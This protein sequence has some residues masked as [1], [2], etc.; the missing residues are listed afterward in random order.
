MRIKIPRKWLKIG[1]VF[2]LLILVVASFLTPGV[3]PAIAQD[4]LSG[5]GAIVSDTQD[6]PVPTGPRNVMTPIFKDGVQIYPIAKQPGVSAAVTVATEQCGGGPVPYTDP[7]NY[8]D[9]DPGDDYLE[10]F[11]VEC[12][13]EHGFPQMQAYVFSKWHGRDAIHDRHD[14]Q[15]IWG[16]MKVIRLSDGAIIEN[17]P[18][19]FTN[20]PRV[21]REQGKPVEEW[22][23]RWTLPADGGEYKIVIEGWMLQETCNNGSGYAKAEYIGKRMKPT[24]TSMPSA[25]PKPHTPT[26]RPTNTPVKPTDTA[27]PQLPTNTP[28]PSATATNTALPT[29][30][31]TPPH[32]AT[33]TGTN[34][35][36]PTT[37]P[38]H[39]ATPTDTPTVVVLPSATPTSVPGVVLLPLIYHQ[40]YVPPAPPSPCEGMHIQVDA[41]FSGQ[42]YYPLGLGPHYP[43]YNAGTVRV[44]EVYSFGT[45]GFASSMTRYWQDS[46]HS[47]PAKYYN[48]VGN[49]G[50]WLNNLRVTG[51]FSL[52]QNEMISKA[53]NPVSG[54]NITQVA[55]VRAQ[56]SFTGID[57]LG[58]TCGIVFE[59][60]FDPPGET[61]A[62]AASFV[63]SGT[64]LI[65]DTVGISSTLVITE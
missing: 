40:S 65:S 39:T 15:R 54:Q 9:I 29:P 3:Q 28:L 27:T 5:Y 41:T 22:R 61:V 35:A 31:N 25:T 56:Q 12:V 20:N 7:N 19:S 51:F 23:Y 14:W 47:V 4:D 62:A 57:D 21:D 45:I 1:N 38:T 59:Q 63:L 34:T 11:A 24:P 48:M 58:N 50:A 36:T 30:V 10:A 17:I 44:D 2:F 13:D 6:A 33:A 37:L 60:V 52:D 49:D 42:Q 64:T 16:D 43:V 26:P 8:G 46:F 32:T 55:F 53:K 18:F